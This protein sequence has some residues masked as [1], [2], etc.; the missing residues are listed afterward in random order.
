MS[1]RLLAHASLPL[2]LSTL[3]FQVPAE[4]RTVKWPDG[5]V[6]EEYEFVRGP[7]DDEIRQG[8]YRSWFPSGTLAC[9]GE[10]EANVET[11][12][13]TFHHEDGSIESSGR[14]TEGLRAGVWEYFHD[15]GKRAAK[16]A[17]AR[18]HRQG[19]W[20]VWFA[21]GT[22]D[23]EN[24]GVYEFRLVHT[25]RLGQDASGELLDGQPHGPWKWTW[26]DLTSQFEGSF[27]HGRREGPWVF[28]HRDGTVSSSFLS[29]MYSNGLWSAPLSSQ[30]EE[31]VLDLSLLPP[32]EDAPETW[33]SV[34]AEFEAA[35][36]AFLALQ[37]NQLAQGLDVSDRNLLARLEP[38]W[39]GVQVVPCILTRMRAL[40]PSRDVDRQRLGVLDSSVLRRACNGRPLS[41][42]RHGAPTSASAAREI[43]RSWSS[44]WS[45]A[46]DEAQLW[47]IDLYA[48][49]SGANDL[50]DR[51]MLQNLRRL[52][53]E[54]DGAPGL[55]PLY[56][57]RI[58]ASAIKQDATRKALDRALG[59]IIANPRF[60]GAWSVSHDSREPSTSIEPGRYSVGVTGLAILAILGDMNPG[61]DRRL[62]WAALW[63]AAWLAR[64][65]E[66][67]GRMRSHFSHPD[68]QAETRKYY[69]DHWLYEHAIATAAL[70][71]AIAVLH[72]DSLRPAATKAVGLIGKARNPYNAWRYTCPPEGDNDTSV[73]IWMVF[74]LASAREAGVSVDPAAFEGAMNWIDEV[75]DP[76]TGRSGYNGMGGLP[77]RTQERVSEFPA[78]KS[79]SMTA[80]AMLC[81]VLSGHTLQG[82]PMISKGA[83]LLVRALPTWQTGGDI[84]FYYWYYGTL[85]MHHVGGPSWERWNEAMKTAIIDHQRVNATEDEYGSWDPIDP[86]S[87]EG[88]RIYSTAMLA[89]SLEAPWRFRWTAPEAA[90]KKR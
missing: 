66:G 5:T 57:G 69:D 63:G 14:F 35:W 83:E 65:Q 80:A 37:P 87:S 82:D 56:Q 44:I 13:W 18:G 89:M 64:Q 68:E 50:S 77:S 75:T 79:E 29:G 38:L 62:Y 52:G 36:N 25:S 9:E 73:T 33:P 85:A 43:V 7:Q 49:S 12:H 71:E 51:G 22:E 81:R 67:D 74:A 61:R 24:S 31:V 39:R 32:V 19:R 42:E 3:G 41:P 60:D 84:D 70:C 15:N 4:R 47:W 58:S 16:G 10:F 90:K 40:D 72:L 28:H 46:R 45:L 48:D 23:T 26:P 54:I 30:D 27:V 55:P 1:K 17:F 86:W 34:A 76:N 88:G 8:T 53:F 59:W 6:K 2:I 11:G 21:E 78:E 20:K